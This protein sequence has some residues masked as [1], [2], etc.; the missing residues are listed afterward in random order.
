MRP[1]VRGVVDRAVQ[2][3]ATWAGVSTDRQ[4]ATRTMAQDQ[5]SAS[6]TAS[7]PFT[8]AVVT[9]AWADPSM[10]DVATLAVVTVQ[11]VARD[12]GGFSGLVVGPIG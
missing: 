11:V 12:V 4:K 10:F 1:A 9:P 7:G 6:P 5:A 2:R 3:S 8:L